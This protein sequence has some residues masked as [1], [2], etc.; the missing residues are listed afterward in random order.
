MA[1][2]CT[3]AGETAASPLAAVAG[4]DMEAVEALKLELSL[5]LSLASKSFARY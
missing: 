2:T 3:S 4:A 1:P 5:S